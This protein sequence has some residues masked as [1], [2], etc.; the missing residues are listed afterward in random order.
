MYFLVDG[1]CIKKSRVVMTE[2]VRH[3]RVMKKLQH[4][5][6]EICQGKSMI[7]EED[8]ER[9]H[10]LRAV[11]KENF[12]LHIPPPLLVPRMATEDVKVMGYDIRAGTQVIVNAWAIGRDPT[13]WEEP[14]EF[15]PERFLKNP[16]SYKGVHF[17]WL[18]FGAGR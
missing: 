10:Y 18:P 13:L 8:L 16:F 14:E 17:E 11:I 15:R 12:R 9:M 5:V 7:T 1:Y 4:E 3:P 2:L 6:A